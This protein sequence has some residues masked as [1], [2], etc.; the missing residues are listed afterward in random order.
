VRAWR[1]RAICIRVAVIVA[2]R[3]LGLRGRHHG[4]FAF[5]ERKIDWGEVVAIGPVVRLC[6]LG[7]TQ[8]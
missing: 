3:V 2:T 4:L 6:A 8:V 5:Q 7:D 1:W